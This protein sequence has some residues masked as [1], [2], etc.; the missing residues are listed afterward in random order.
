MSGNTRKGHLRQAGSAVAWLTLLILLTFVLQLTIPG[1]PQAFIF[2]PKTALTKPWVFVTSMFLHAGL[3]HLFFNLF[4]LIMFGPLVESRIGSKEFLKIYFLSG[5][6]GSVLYWL[7]IELGLAPAI[8]ALGASGAI[9]GI[10][11]AAAVYFPR[12]IVYSFGFIPLKMRDALIL[13][14]AMEFLGIF[15]PYSG[16]ASAA[17]VGGIIIGYLYAKRLKREENWWESYFYAQQ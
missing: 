16:I 1:F 9:Y 12:L 15:N 2:N 14:F 11:A 8:P 13:W 6:G 4:A 10:M 5:I 3:E 7:T 17:H